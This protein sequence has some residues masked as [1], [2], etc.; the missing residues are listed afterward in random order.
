M[1]SKEEKSK[2]DERKSYPLRLPKTTL[3]ALKAR[4]LEEDSSV[5]KILERLIESYLAEG[6]VQP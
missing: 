2:K 5:Q 1:K 3:K 4:A 6:S